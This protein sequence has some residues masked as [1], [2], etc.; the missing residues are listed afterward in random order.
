M[1]IKK[2]KIDI[3]VINKEISRL[4]GFLIGIDKKLSNEKFMANANDEVIEKEHQKKADTL[5]KIA[6]LESQMKKS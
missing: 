1:H 6:S 4:K 5:S 2:Q 3:E